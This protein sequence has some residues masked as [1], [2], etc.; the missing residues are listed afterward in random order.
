MILL[1]QTEDFVSLSSF[2]AWLVANS[3]PLRLS[4]ARLGPNG[5]MFAV[6]TSTRRCVRLS[7]DSSA[8][9]ST[10]GGSPLWCP[11]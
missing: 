9:L 5:L 11:K 10:K 1:T 8:S 7:D 6:K 4:T 3:L 2:I